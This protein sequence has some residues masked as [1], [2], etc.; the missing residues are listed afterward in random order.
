MLGPDTG[1]A[2]RQD[3]GGRACAFCELFEVG[4]AGKGERERGWQ[5][6]WGW[7]E[8][9]GES[10]GSSV[11]YCDGERRHE[12]KGVCLIKSGGV[13]SGKRGLK[14]A[15]SEGGVCV[16]GFVFCFDMLVFDSGTEPLH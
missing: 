7:G 8:E 13:W 15:R 3:G 1:W 2:L 16:F 11:C 9:R 4:T 14:N 6:E 5:D 10:G 12:C